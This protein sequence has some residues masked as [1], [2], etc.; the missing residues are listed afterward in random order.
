MFFAKVITQETRDP[1]MKSIYSRDNILDDEVSGV[2]CFYPKLIV[3]HRIEMSNVKLTRLLV[4]QACSLLG[5]L[6]IGCAKNGSGRSTYACF[7][8]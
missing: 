2:I 8:G 5:S 7:A 6:K 4:P 3:L 1:A